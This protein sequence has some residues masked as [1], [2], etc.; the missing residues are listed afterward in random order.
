MALAFGLAGCRAPASYTYPGIRQEYAERLC[1]PGESQGTGRTAAKCELPA[2]LTL[3]KAIELV[4]RNNPD[5]R[6]T[7]ARIRQAEAMLMASRAPFWPTVGVSTEYLQ[8]DA[9]SAYLF[10]T[11]DQRRLPPMVDFNDPGWF[12]NFES[13]LH[14]G[15]NLYNGGRDA[16]GHEMARRQLAITRL[17]RRDL[18]NRLISATVQT[19]Y[20][21]LAARD[22]IGVARASVATV[23]EELRVMQVRFRAGGALKSDILSLEVRAARASE[24][25]VQSRARLQTALAALTN[26]LGA[27]PDAAIETE[28]L[29]KPGPESVD[30]PADYEAGV[31]Y[32]LQH[33][34]DLQQ[35]RERVVLSR[36]ALDQARAGYLPRVDL[37]TRYWVD[38]EGMDYSRDRDNWTAAVELKWDLFTGL[39]TY[40]EAQKAQAIVEEMLAMDDKAVLGAKLEVKKAYLNLAEADA[41][42]EVAQKSVAKAEESLAL[43]KKQYEGGSATITRYLEAELDTNRARSSAIAAFYDRQMALTAIGSAIGYW[44]QTYRSQTQDR[45][46]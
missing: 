45:Q 29:V 8:G 3:E 25:L 23:K 34:P 42:M 39:S 40:A 36:I 11:I 20:E 46:P 9:P 35:V 13:G 17:Q 32:A 21:S 38:D 30:L 27:P 37:R 15:V 43:V 18:A 5:R 26:L 33:R 41:R 44:S 4:L 19:F 14:A 16:L 7:L 28:A 22:F 10:K 24:Q 12:E 1:P 6:V 31:A 2:R